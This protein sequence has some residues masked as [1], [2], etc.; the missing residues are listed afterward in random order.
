LSG[1]AS[2]GNKRSRERLPGSRMPGRS[3]GAQASSSKAIISCHV[4]RAN[5]LGT[6]ATSFTSDFGDNWPLVP[7]TSPTGVF[8]DRSFGGVGDLLGTSRPYLGNF[9]NVLPLC[10]YCMSLWDLC[11]VDGRGDQLLLHFLISFSYTSVSC[12]I[13]KTIACL[14]RQFLCRLLYSGNVETSLTSRA[15]CSSL[16]SVVVISTTTTS[17]VL[18]T[19][20]AVGDRAAHP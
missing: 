10:H 9:G 19:R 16:V 14:Q 6:E 18:T 4:Q 7:F 1:C 15:P 3:V 2:L 20:H 12:T 5:C 17:S 8:W 13:T 11:G